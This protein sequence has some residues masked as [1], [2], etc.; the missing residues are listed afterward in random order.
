MDCIA[1]SLYKWFVHGLTLAILGPYILAPIHYYNQKKA[2]DYSVLE[3][4]IWSYSY[5]ALHP[6]L[7]PAG[8]PGF[9]Y[10]AIDFSGLLHWLIA[11]FPRVCRC[12]L[13]KRLLFRHEFDL[14]FHDSSKQEWWNANPLQCRTARPHARGTPTGWEGDDM[15]PRWSGK[16]SPRILGLSA[17]RW[18][19]RY[20]C[21]S[22]YLWPSPASTSVI[23]Q[24]YC[25]SDVAS[26]K[27]RLYCCSEFLMFDS[28]NHFHLKWY[29]LICLIVSQR[30]FAHCLL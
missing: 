13:F 30:L 26:S 10:A 23:C 21:A 11:F 27:L 7:C 12:V 2:R 9:I 3:F 15:A 4:A 25:Y 14:C 20:I 8:S 22:P 28:I 24:Y 19:H 17:P 29:Q 1:M 5:V 16:L 6:P 18:V